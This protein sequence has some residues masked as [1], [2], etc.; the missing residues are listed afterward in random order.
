[1]LQDDLPHAGVDEI[2]G[3]AGHTPR[4]PTDRSVQK[5][6]IG[7]EHAQVAIEICHT[8]IRLFFPDIG[9]TSRCLH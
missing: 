1:M 7:L 8:E 6:I 4:V 5:V 2:T 9:W 3:N